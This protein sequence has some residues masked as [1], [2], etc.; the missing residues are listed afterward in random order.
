MENTIPPS[1]PS[2]QW[3]KTGCWQWLGAPQGEECGF[4]A[5]PLWAKLPLSLRLP[6]DYRRQRM[7]GGRKERR[8]RMG[9]YPHPSTSFCAPLTL[10]CSLV[11]IE[12][13][14]DVGRGSMPEDRHKGAVT[15]NTQQTCL[16]T[17]CQARYCWG[18]GW[19]VAVWVLF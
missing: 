4:Q 3:R 19:G 11:P 17:L 15:V 1:D 16:T 6:G 14:E 18:W 12:K 5:P 13:Q 9:K 7:E 10:E 2:Q 8:E